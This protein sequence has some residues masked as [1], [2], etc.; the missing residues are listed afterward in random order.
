MIDAMS[1]R[2]ISRYHIVLEFPT[3]RPPGLISATYS[4]T[5]WSQRR[6]YVPLAR[7]TKLVTYALHSCSSLVMWRHTQHGSLTSTGCTSQRGSSCGILTTRRSTRCPAG[8]ATPGMVPL[9]SYT[10]SCGFH[11]LIKHLA[12][13]VLRRAYDERSL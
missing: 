2:D 8:R 5:Y 7:Y 4:R 10:V 3:Q 11:E 12:H 6:R 1:T 13:A 9:Y